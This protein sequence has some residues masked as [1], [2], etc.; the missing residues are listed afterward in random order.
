MCDHEL[1]VKD[2]SFDHEHGCE[3][4]FFY[5]CEKCGATNDDDKSIPDT[6]E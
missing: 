2:E 4:V 5:E 6:V 3:Q 1:V